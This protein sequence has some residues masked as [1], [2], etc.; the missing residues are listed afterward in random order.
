MG[1]GRVRLE[2]SGIK[3]VAK[4]DYRFWSEGNKKITYDVGHKTSVLDLSNV[5]F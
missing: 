5:F 3:S 4:G 2:R 1:L